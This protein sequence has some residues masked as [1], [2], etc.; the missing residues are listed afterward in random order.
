MILHLTDYIQFTT[1]IKSLLENNKRLKGIV[2]EWRLGDN[3]EIEFANAYPLV[4]VTN[5]T[6]T[7]VSRK[8]ITSS[9]YRKLPGQERVLE[10]WIII[11]CRKETPLETQKEISK[12]QDIIIDILEDNIQ[13]RKKDGSDPLCALAEIL[14]Q[15]R[16][17]KL[18]GELTEA[19]TIRFRPIIYVDKKK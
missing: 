9:D 1:R 15:K 17:E 12:I 4:F 5:A 16:Y 10:F 14:L 6:Q 19:I 3:A 2:A 8:T 11:V 18:R 13:L 7:E